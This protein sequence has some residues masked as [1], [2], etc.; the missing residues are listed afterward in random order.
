MNSLLRR[1]SKIDGEF[2]FHAKVKQP[3][4]AIMGNSMYLQMM[5]HLWLKSPSLH[6]LFTYL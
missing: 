2:S 1:I 4:F 5:R 3:D 6:L